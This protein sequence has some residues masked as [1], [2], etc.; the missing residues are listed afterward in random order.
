MF[1]VIYLPLKSCCACC[2]FTKDIW[3]NCTDVFRRRTFLSLKKLSSW[4]KFIRKSIAIESKKKYIKY[5][6]YIS[7]QILVSLPRNSFASNIRRQTF[8]HWSTVKKLSNQ[9]VLDNNLHHRT[10]NIQLRANILQ[11]KLTCNSVL[12]GKINF[13][14]LVSIDDIWQKMEELLFKTPYIQKELG[15]TARSILITCFFV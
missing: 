14:S 5:I 2:C 4:W 7:T 11:Q 12:S 1:L 10:S 9:R 3:Y 8:K 15:I 13:T 6:K